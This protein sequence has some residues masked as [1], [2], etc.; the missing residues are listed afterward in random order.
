MYT[1]QSSACNFAYKAHVFN[2]N[3]W[4]SQ[5]PWSIRYKEVSSLLTCLCN[6]Q[7]KFLAQGAATR[8]GIAANYQNKMYRSFRFTASMVP[9]SCGNLFEI[10]HPSIAFSSFA[11]QYSSCQ[12]RPVLSLCHQQKPAT[13][14]V[15]SVKSI[16][17]GN[18]GN[19]YSFT[20]S[21]SSSIWWSDGA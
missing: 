16:L 10:H 5:H 20:D 1:L 15:Q 9:L 8:V 13:L 18:F 7:I 3:N 4:W 12:H 11:M 21:C 17:S 19:W 6:D 14:A 2:V